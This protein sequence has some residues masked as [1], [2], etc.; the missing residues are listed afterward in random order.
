MVRV[1]RVQDIVNVEVSSHEVALLTTLAEIA[2]QHVA[3]DD[4]D[5]PVVRRLLPDAYADDVSASREYAE[6]MNDD[7]RKQKLDAL[8]AMV[9]EAAGSSDEGVELSI[10]QAEGWLQAL[11]D[12]R[13][14]IGT[15]LDVTEDWVE[16]AEALD[17]DDPRLAMYAAYDWASLLQ[18]L[19]VREVSA[20]G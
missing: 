12:V 13:L 19:L 8:Q 4:R 14:V 2:A 16:Q 9:T 6:L 1:R 17:E 5:D 3:D 10:E 15:K 18:E 7:L 11:N 20:A